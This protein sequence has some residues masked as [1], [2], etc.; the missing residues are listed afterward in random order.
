MLIYVLNCSFKKKAD[1]N[2]IIFFP[3]SLFCETLFHSLFFFVFIHF[4]FMIILFLVNFFLN[5]YI[6]I[7]WM[8][9]PCWSHQI[10]QK[11]IKRQFVCL[12]YEIIHYL[13][14]RQI[15]TALFQIKQNYIEVT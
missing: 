5:N 9:F 10:T 12:V 11:Q 4:I 15:L 14:L 1:Y 2:A 13:L 6:F 8:D 3:S 7:G